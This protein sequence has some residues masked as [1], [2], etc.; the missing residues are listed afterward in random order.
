MIRTFLIS[1]LAFC[2]NAPAA[3][4]YRGGEVLG[5]F[6]AESVSVDSSQFA[7][8]GSWQPGDPILN[9]P[10]LRR[11]STLVDPLPGTIDTVAQRNQPTGTDSGFGNVTAIDGQAF[12]GFI[13]PDSDGAIGP[14][15]YIQIVNG[16][17][18]GGGIS[19]VVA[20]YDKQHMSIINGPFV[21]E[22]LGSGA[23]ASGAGDGIALYDQ[24]AD[25]W[26][27][28]EF[29]TSDLRRLCIYVSQTNDPTAGSWFAYQVS[30]PFF[31]DYPKYSIWRN[32]YFVTTNEQA[33]AVYALQRD[34]MLQGA[35][36]SV[37]RFAIDDL[38]GFNFNTLTPA[39]I[40][41]ARLPDAGS[42]ALFMRHVDDEAH[43]PDSADPNQ[44]WLQLWQFN[45]AW[46]SPQDSSFFLSQTL[47]IAEFS[48][49]LCGLTA[50][51]CIPQTG[52]SGQLDVLR[53][54]IMWRLS[55]RR[56]SNYDVLVGN[57]VTNVDPVGTPAP[58]NPA[59]VRWFELRQYG[60]I[61][62][63]ND[64]VVHQQGTWAPDDS[65]R[66]MASIAMDGTGN[67][68]LAYNVSDQFGTFPGLRY[69]GQ[70]FDA[71]SGALSEP[72]HVIVDGTAA[73]AGFR[74]GDYASMRIDPTD[75]CTFWFTGEYNQDP[76]W[77]TQIA[78]FRFDRC[79]GNEDFIFA[80]GFE[81]A[82]DV[83]IVIEKL[84]NG[85]DADLP[86]GP[87][88][89]VGEPVDWFY[90]V[91]NTGNRPLTQVA[92][93]DSEGELVSC[94]QDS[95]LPKE[96]MLCFAAGTAISGQYSNVGTVTAVVYEGQPEQQD[97]TDQDTS[98][99][100]GVDPPP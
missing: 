62:G 9:A 48:S 72:E 7:P 58:P 80:D 79:N 45:L 21:L 11:G 40:D 37:Q 12:T 57:M 96:A 44:D 100:I 65:H 88:I 84:T 5:P 82:P 92:V 97:I 18:S 49:D 17:D 10:R 36:A 38:P 59:G 68:A 51:S 56:F 69:S 71:P 67:I 64:W 41:G 87:E 42:P 31:P 54:V 2:A 35:P 43:F 83:A 22:E 47:P 26:I 77:S 19:S 76:M 24:F 34:A 25:R 93:E 39:D 20:I 74:Y 63:L 28:T 4:R 60:P 78:T 81:P 99:Y 29:S 95:L 46:L 30:A 86:P 8:P 85:V 89:V 52:T 16:R 6:A 3:D 15:H 55:Y 23:C 70:A 90:F 61:R 50:T 53:E 94:P 14:S 27:L 75:D 33:P 91:Q 98:H 66:W 73:N 1:A 32:A 13:P